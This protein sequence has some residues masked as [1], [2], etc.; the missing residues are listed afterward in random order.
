[1]PRRSRRTGGARVACQ[2]WAVEMCS[3][4][5]TYSEDDGGLLGH[6]LRNIHVHLE[7]GRVWTEVVDA[8]ET[9]R[10]DNRC[11]RREAAEDSRRDVHVDWRLS[12]V[13]V[14]E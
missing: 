2:F 5:S 8:H 4:R 6:F 14:C 12:C 1:M 9:S 13:C 7:V 3:G 10:I 11:E